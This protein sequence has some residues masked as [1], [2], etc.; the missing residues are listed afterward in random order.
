M[1]YSLFHAFLACHIVTGTVALVAFW[2]PVVGTKGAKAHRTWGRVFVFAVLA[3]GT[4]GLGMSLL[5]IAAPFE[6]H[7]H[8]KD[9]HVIRGLLGWMMLYL[10]TMTITLAWNGY[11]TAKNRLNHA[12]N[13][14][15]LN[16]G[17]HVATLTTALICAG[18]GV[19]TREPLMIGISGLGLAAGVL[20]LRFMFSAAPSRSAYVD[21]HMKSTVG[22]GTSVY[23]AFISVGLVRWL[24]QEAFN[25]LIWG[26]PVAVG[27]SLILFHTRRIA[28]G[29]QWQAQ[30]TEAKSGKP[31]SSAT[32]AT[33]STG[34][35]IA[36]S[37]SEAYG[38]AKAR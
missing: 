33:S 28:G 26:L 36:A 25:P 21:Q 27:V 30:L 9:L 22:A 3:T 37:P 10:A 15:P 18:Y 16:V 23:T 17:L 13:R 29:W 2:L 6:T 12:K 5:S 14:S 24:P 4:S 20:N 1:A 32:I 8:I 11:V 7:P 35:D 31:A 19:V 38:K 34:A